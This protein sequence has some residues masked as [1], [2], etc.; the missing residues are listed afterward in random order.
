MTRMQRILWVLILFCF[1]SPY[2]N[3]VES[4]AQELPLS[5]VYSLLLSG[6]ASGTSGSYSLGGIVSGLTGTLEI[7]E[8]GA[9]NLIITADG[10]FTF[11]SPVEENTSYTISVVS[12]PAGYGCTITNGTGIMPGNDVNNISIVCA[13]APMYTL[14]GTVSGLTGSLEITQNGA[15]NLTI[16]TDGPFTFPTSVTYNHPYLVEVVSTPA[17]YDCVISNAGGVMPNNDV[18]DV[19]ITCAVDTTP[20]NKPLLIGGGQTNDPLY[21]W[22]WT[23]GGG[24][25]GTYRYSL[26]CVWPYQLNDTNSI[27]TTDTQAT[28]ASPLP[29]GG[30]IM[31]VQERD[32]A[33][34]WSANA[35]KA[36]SLNTVSPTVTVTIPEDTAAQ[37]SVKKNLVITF[38]KNMAYIP[39]NDGVEYITLVS[40]NGVQI[41]LQIYYPPSGGS[42]PDAYEFHHT[43]PLEENETYT[44]TVT[45]NVKDS[46]GNTLEQ[47]Y[48]F[49]FTTRDPTAYYPAAPN[50]ND[51][52]KNDGP[53]IFNATGT[54]CD[55]T[56]TGGY[57]ACIHSGELRAFT[58]PGQNSCVGLT[59][60]DNNGFLNWTCLDNTG[61]VCF[62]STGLKKDVRLVDLV[63]LQKWPESSLIV[64]DGS[65]VVYTTDPEQWWSNPIRSFVGV[66]HDFYLNEEGTIYVHTGGTTYQRDIFILANKIALVGFPGFPIYSRDNNGPFVLGGG[67][68]LWIEGEF[69]GIGDTE[70]MSFE[71][72]KFSVLRYIS[73]MGAGTQTN[74]WGLRLGNGSNNNKIEHVISKLNTYGIRI[75]NSRDNS[76]EDC[77]LTM[78]GNAGLWVYSSRGNHLNNIISSNNLIGLRLQAS[79]GNVITGFTAAHNS[80]FGLS[81]TDGSDDNVISNSTSAKN[82][83]FGL[84]VEGSSN[85][86]IFN[87]LALV[88]NAVHGASISASISNTFQNMA[89]TNSG[90]VSNLFASSPDT[91]TYGLFMDSS[92]GYFTGRLIFGT[93][94]DGSEND[95]VVSGSTG[96]TDTCGVADGSDFTVTTSSPALGSFVGKAASDSANDEDSNGGA[97]FPSTV[98][99]ANAFDW[100]SFERP[101]R[102]WGAEVYA[103][104]EYNNTALIDVGKMGCSSNNFVLTNA[105][106]AYWHE[107]WHDNGHIWDW[108]IRVGDTLIRNSLSIP[109]NGDAA[110]TVTH[111]WSDNSTAT[112]LRNAVEKKGNGN[113][114]CESG[115]TC[116]YTPN[117]G[118]YQGHG[119]LQSAGSFTNGDTLSGIS[120]E[121]FSTNGY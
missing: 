16:T 34:N 46:Y 14:G 90:P 59:A 94:G 49:H 73:V 62:V 12:A 20:P 11:P 36:L 63:G 99:A 102:T 78:N 23:S 61:E 9:N 105:Y 17:G 21:T 86:N 2:L 100:T 31:C 79:D 38:S 18:S 54:P 114:L 81:L 28:P 66:Q 7:N 92:G 98:V 76:L 25:N 26:P 57:G 118:S 13:P 5:A 50:W 68:F 72:L 33:G 104:D 89:M 32:D 52:V 64:S 77:F 15:D 117:I 112:F 107:Y 19:L 85:N 27:T 109:A 29:D 96:I 82:Q 41:P 83:R 91:V 106:C 74:G 116:L 108:N 69:N 1:F 75:E 70:V 10:S 24:G 3:P 35:S 67:N 45:Q 43:A 111:T 121:E 103:T 110:N 87:N 51:Y 42:P 53:D 97:S 71:Q 120:L 58:I 47:P 113:G 39:L 115:E 40:S 93:N 60:E 119:G 65:G 56:E 37:Q 80:S 48:V 30:Y 4:S 95:C 6:E 101:L 88:G 8:N 84:N 44:V 55:G 22:T